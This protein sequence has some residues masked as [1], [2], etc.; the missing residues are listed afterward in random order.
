[1]TIGIFLGEQNSGK[2][3]SMSYYARLYYQKG[4][5]IYS[6]YKL[7]FPHITITRKMMEE[8][9]TSRKQFNKAIFCID[10]IYLFFD[11]RS[12][13]SK[14]NKLFTYFLVQSSKNSVNIFGTAQY[15]DTI[16]K[17]F[18]NNTSFK[19]FCTRVNK[20][21]NSFIPIE[22]NIRK[23]EDSSRLYIRN[24]FLIKTIKDFEMKIRQKIFYIKAEPLFN[25]Y[26][27]TELI[28]IIE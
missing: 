9:T 23:L 4:Y 2:T 10:E 25:I 15:F 7:N 27:T 26:D 22:S 19:V 6:N 8:Y 17:R 18:R 14:A 21:N 11:S 24:C 28:N 1:M 12:F 16:E 3:L 20:I 13:G 5:T